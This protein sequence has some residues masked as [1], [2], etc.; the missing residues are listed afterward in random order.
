MRRRLFDWGREVAID[1]WREAKERV[2]ESVDIV[3]LAGSYLDLHR[4]G[5]EYLALCPWHDD[6]R[7]SLHVNP[8]RQTFKCF[9][10]DLGGDIFSFVMQMEGV[11]FR[12]AVKMLAERAGIVIEPPQERRGPASAEDDKQTLYDA[13]AW[14]EAAYHGF[15]TESP[16]AEPARRY[17]QSRH[18]NDQSIARF[19]IGYAPDRWDWLLSQAASAGFSPRVLEKVGLIA[20]RQSGSG[21]YDRFRGRVLFPIHDAHVREAR[22]IALGGRIL[23]ELAKDEVAKY[24]NS[25]ESPIYSKN[26]QLYALDQAREAI[27]KAKPKTVLVMEGYTDVVVAHQFG[28]DNAVAVCGTAL[29]ENHLG[30]LRRYAD[31]ITLVLDGDEAGKRRTNEILELFVAAQLDLQILTLPQ[32][33][34][35]CDFLV[36]HGSEAFRQLLAE[37]VDALEHKIRTGTEGL[38]PT[39]DTHRANAVLE[40][41]LGTM[42]RAPRLASST[43]AAVRLREQ[44]VLSR[45]AHTFRVPEEQLRLRMSELR[46]RSPRGV[47]PSRPSQPISPVPSI[48]ALDLW[49]RELLELVMLMPGSIERVASVI[50]VDDLNSPV[51]RRIYQKCLELFEA[52]AEPSF[53]QLM[54]E[55]EEPSIKNLLV[56]FEE[57]GRAKAQSDAGQWLAE[58]LASFQGRKEDAELE[59]RLR[60]QAGAGPQTDESLLGDLLNT[61][62][63]RPGKLK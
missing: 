22:P 30:L 25:P 42:A 4:R 44:Q 14:A 32:N 28:I 60:E 9:V 20:A 36:T 13:M 35:P 26:R 21:F 47:E 43:A 31:R 40:D 45:L 6:S 24:I 50:A 29:G 12:E 34:D 1:Q 53:D 51:C 54:L 19:R 52:G 48:D 39:A 49:D 61:L 3:D 33:L 38:D 17:L 57:H 63:S 55:A 7:P 62:R 56:R 8:E 16:E 41:V 5:R 18:I 59:T 11:G 23:P 37:A 27:L 15:L 46:R 2:R 10:C 58:V